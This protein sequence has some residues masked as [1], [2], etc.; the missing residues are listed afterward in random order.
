VQWNGS[1][2]WGANAE[3]IVNNHS[4]ENSLGEQ[5]PLA[6]IYERFGHILSISVSYDTNTSLHLAEYRANFPT[7]TYLKRGAPIIENGLRKW[8]TFNDLD[9]DSYDF[10]EI[11]KDYEEDR[12]PI[13]KGK[14]GYA[15]S[16]LIPQRALVDFAVIWIERNKM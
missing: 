6:R 9:Y 4:L 3:Y 15:E 5:S 7:K 10:L 14:I 13:S 11:G 12:N 1:A 8:V 2:A 16:T